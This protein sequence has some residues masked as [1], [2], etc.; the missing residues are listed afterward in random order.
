[1]PDSQHTPT[2]ALA[3]SRRITERDAD[4]CFILMALS[5][6]RQ[7]ADVTAS[8]FM[9]RHVLY[10]YRRHCYQADAVFHFIRPKY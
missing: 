2:S 6:M 3:R 5:A 10:H 1:M 9:R 7:A 8:S 4:A